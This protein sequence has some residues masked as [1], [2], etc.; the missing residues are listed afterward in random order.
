MAGENETDTV[1]AMSEGVPMKKEPDGTLLAWSNKT[2]E[3]KPA[4]WK[5]ALWDYW[6]AHPTTTERLA[7]IG[8]TP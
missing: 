7:K 3:W 4:W 8:V 2:G 5:D 1:Y 6:Y